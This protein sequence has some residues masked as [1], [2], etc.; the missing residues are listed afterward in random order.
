MS[1]ITIR[2]KIKVRVGV[3]VRIRVIDRVMVKVTVRYIPSKVQNTL[4]SEKDGF[5]PLLLSAGGG[6]VGYSEKRL[7]VQSQSL[8]V[9]P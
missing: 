2:F 4:A 7:D 3:R 5:D 8:T 1:R 6:L 9:V